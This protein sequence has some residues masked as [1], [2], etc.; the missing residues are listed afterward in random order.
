MLALF[1]PL[2][3]LFL[4]PTGTFRIAAPSCLATMA[5]VTPGLLKTLQDSCQV[6]TSTN[7]LV[8]LTRF[9]LCAAIVAQP[10]SFLACAK[11]LA[12]LFS[13]LGSNNECC[14]P[15]ME[16]DSVNVSYHHP[17]IYARQTTDSLSVSTKF[18]ASSDTDSPRGES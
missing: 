8:S 12:T 1:I 13:L 7:P 5:L 3:A 16:A 4:S 14:A 9:A 2:S 15:S 18:P 6:W 11:A 10:P 17:S